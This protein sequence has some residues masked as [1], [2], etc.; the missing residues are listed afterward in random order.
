MPCLRPVADRRACPRRPLRRAECCFCGCHGQPHAAGVRQATRR[1]RCRCLEG[2]P[3]FGLRAICVAQGPWS[4]RL[5]FDRPFRRVVLVVSVAAPHQLDR[6]AHGGGPLARFALLLRRVALATGRPHRHAKHDLR[7][8]RPRGRLL[9]ADCDGDVHRG[10]DVPVGVE[11]GVQR[12]HRRQVR[13]RHRA[14]ACLAGHTCARCAR[15]SRGGRLAPATRLR[16]TR[17]VGS[18]LRWLLACASARGELAAS[19]ALAAGR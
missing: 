14:R 1:A 4:Q 7:V 10:P 18:A 12:R 8:L 9:C 11:R 13:G 5:H 19:V 2:R 17:R 15:R 6:R 3:E 16:R